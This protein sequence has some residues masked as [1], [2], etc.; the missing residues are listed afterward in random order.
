MSKKKRILL[1][2]DRSAGHIFPAYSL[3]KYLKER[4][5]VYFFTTSEYFK[6]K[7]RTNGFYFLGKEFSYRNFFLEMCFRFIEALIIL[8]TVKPEKIIGFGGRGSFFLV[9]LGAVFLVNTSLYE[10]NAKFGKANNIL[11]FFVRNVY[12]GFPQ[13]TLSRKLKKVGIPIRDTLEGRDKRE[14]KKALGF[15]E[16]IPVVL[17]CGGSQGSKFINR[18]CKEIVLKKKENI[19]IIHLTG[20]EEYSAFATFYDKIVKMRYFVCDFY[21]EMGFLYSAADVVIARAGAASVA[22]LSFFKIPAIFIPLPG[23]SA[24]QKENARL[25]EKEGA[26]YLFLQEKVCIEDVSTALDTLLYN[27]NIR[28]T[29]IKNIE[30]LHLWVSAQEFYKSIFCSH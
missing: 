17:C 20:Q 28:N 19:Q 7:I 30:S 24:H 29:F 9:L 10:P 25:F 4:N 5:E 22:E 26:A 2:T 15:D 8:V 13:H 11:K 18:I 23:A 27:Q 3:V 12:C 6:N 21:H 14:A 16:N 1:A